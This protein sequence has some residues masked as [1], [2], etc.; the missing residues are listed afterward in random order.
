MKVEVALLVTRGSISVSVARRWLTHS[1]GVALPTAAITAKIW[2]IWSAAMAAGPEG[3]SCERLPLGAQSLH[4]AQEDLHHSNSLSNMQARNPVH[5]LKN[6][7]SV[8]PIENRASRVF[9]CKSASTSTEQGATN[10]SLQTH[11]RRS[12]VDAIPGRG[13]RQNS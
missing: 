8:G 2:K 5:P 11:P 6:T 4:Q 9:R 3:H 1:L 7:S 13:V 10:T 12:S